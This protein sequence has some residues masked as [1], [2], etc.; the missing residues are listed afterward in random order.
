MSVSV[1]LFKN[2]ELNLLILAEYLIRHILFTLTSLHP[3]LSLKNFPDKSY[4]Q[5]NPL[6]QF[7]FKCDNFIYCIN[8]YRDFLLETHKT[9]LQPELFDDFSDNLFNHIS[10]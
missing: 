6:Q 8:N 1:C 4:S 9:K 2:S 7:V 5:L 10:V 3:E